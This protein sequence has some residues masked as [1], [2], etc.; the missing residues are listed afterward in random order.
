MVKALS[1]TR[2]SV[3]VG[4][5][6]ALIVPNIASARSASATT[7]RTSSGDVRG[8]EANDVL[9][10]KGIRYGASTAGDGRFRPPVP[11]PRER[12]VFDASGFGDQAPQSR[13]ALADAGPMSEDCLRI[14]IWTPRLDR[15]PR[16][17]MIWFHGGGFEAGSASQTLYDGA[18]LARRGD[19]VVVTINHRLNVFGHCHLAAQLG[20]DYASSGNVGF[21][22]LVMA[23]R[24]VRRNIAGFGGNPTNIT[25]FGQSGGGR[26]VSLCYASPASEG[27]FQRGIVQSGSH[28]MVQTPA[29]AAALTNRLLERLSIT[30]NDARKLLSVPVNAIVDAQREVIGEMGYRFEPVLDGR[31]FTQQPFVPSAPRRTQNIPMMVGTTRT[32]LSNQLG[33]ADPRLF[34]L[35]EALLP[36]AIARF[37]GADK[38]SAAIA[39]VRRYRRD[40][41]APEVLFTVATNRAYGLDST[42]MAQARAAA[43]GKGAAKT[44]LYRLMW[45][46]P[47]QGGRRITPHSL[48]LPFVFD[49]VHAGEALAGPPTDLTTAMANQMAETWLAFARTGDPNNRSIPTWLPYDVEQRTMMLFDLPPRAVSD[50]FKDEREFFAQFPTQQGSAGRYR[51]AGS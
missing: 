25:I 27:L 7:V 45:R 18:N 23:M 37:V 39:L 28:L 44:W 21:L 16:P 51:N 3:L 34:D 14:N 8:V 24:W 48:D 47:A 35:P 10:F 33:L 15:K 22:D 2:R 50:P 46:S 38:A 49:N 9:V 5:S 36:G 19:V 17:V 12:G 1:T 40:A 20:S 43:N 32:E 29:Q 30:E 26:K 11:A 4:A 41:T 42:L 6:A 31:V 13:T